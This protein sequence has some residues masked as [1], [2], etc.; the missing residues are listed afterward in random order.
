MAILDDAIL[1]LLDQC[2]A[3]S[4][5]S[6]GPAKRRREAELRA[7]DRSLHRDSQR[8]FRQREG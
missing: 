8:L 1:W 2:R 6:D 4:L 3:T 5:M 7:R